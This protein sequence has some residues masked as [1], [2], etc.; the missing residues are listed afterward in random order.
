MQSSAFFCATNVGCNPFSTLRVVDNY[1]SVHI[2]HA[3]TQQ[4]RSRVFVIKLQRSPGTRLTLS[5]F[6]Q[7]RCCISSV[8]IRNPLRNQNGMDGQTTQRGGELRNSTLENF[9][10][11][12]SVF[13][14]GK[15]GVEFE[16]QSSVVSLTCCLTLS[17]KGLYP[18]ERGALSRRGLY[19]SERG[20][21]A[22]GSSK[23][24]QIRKV[25][26][27]CFDFGYNLF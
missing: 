6:R 8:E 3:G 25:N 22:R 18:S 15:R 7:S 4:K 24:N 5:G 17:R 14:S 19:P 12:R 2:L 9:N 1:L 26:L 21:G 16:V 20:G 27:L 13:K 10:G 23:A 11:Q